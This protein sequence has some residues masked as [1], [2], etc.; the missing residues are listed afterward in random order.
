M[1]PNTGTRKRRRARPGVR[2]LMIG[3]PASAAA[4][5][6]G[7]ALAEPVP[8]PVHIKPHSE[9]IAYA[10]ELVLGGTESPADAG[11]IVA[12]QFAAHGASAWSDV[13]STTVGGDGRFRLTTRLEPLGRRARPRHVERR[14]DRIRD[15][16][17]HHRDPAGEQHRPGRS[18]G[19]DAR[20][21]PPDRRSGRPDRVGPRSAAA[22]PSWGA[23]SASR[24]AR[25][26]RGERSPRLAPAP[27]AGLY[28]AM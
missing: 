6:A 27:R 24:H 28:C 22:A 11:H 18:R 25:T 26:A 9:H 2:A 15:R 14:P 16:L 23:R 17:Q 5:S 19:R 12:L 3:I 7:H 20:S 10:Q 4:L 13:S 1:R 21:C 8:G